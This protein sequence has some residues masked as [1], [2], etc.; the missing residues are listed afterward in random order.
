MRRALLVL[1][2]LLGCKKAVVTGDDAAAASPCA[3]MA[4]LAG[5]PE[6]LELESCERE[7]DA[8]LAKKPSVHACVVACIDPAET[9]AV[10]QK[11]SGKCMRDAKP[12]HLGPEHIE[13]VS[14]SAVCKIWGAKQAPA[15]VPRDDDA[16]TKTLDALKR[17]APAKFACQFE[18]T[19]T[20]DKTGT[21]ADLE[22]CTRACP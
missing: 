16:C 19:L 5:R 2:L 13:H 17:D 12:D 11:C 10:F 21:W 6:H 22:A 20:H 15:G 8:M 3:R 7:L 18:C 4:K 14:P 1:L 9:F